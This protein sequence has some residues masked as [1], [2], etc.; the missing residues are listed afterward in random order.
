MIELSK[1]K[2]MKDIL[3]YAYN[4]IP[5]YKDVLKG[6]DMDNDV[7]KV[8]E[9]IPIQ[10]KMKMRDNE[11]YINQRMKCMDIELV[12]KITGG[13]TGEPWNIT[14]TFLES[15]R[16][17]NMLW[18]S[19]IQFGIKPNDHFYQFGGYGEIDGVFT[20]KQVIET[21]RFTE[22][23]MFHLNDRVLD[24]YIDIIKGGKGNWF[25]ANPSALYILAHRMRDRKIRGLG[26][27]KYV[28][29]TGERVYE[30]Q[31]ALI[32]EVFD[33][34][35]S[36]MYGS[37]E[38]TCISHRC[39][40]GKHHILPKVFVDVIDDDGKSIVSQEGK[41]GE[42]VV[43]SF[44]DKYMPFIKYRTG[45]YGIIDTTDDCPCGC[46]GVYFKKL[47]G[48][49]AAYVTVGNIKVHLEITYYLMEKFN[50]I[51]GEGI[52]QFQVIFRKPN[53]FHFKFVLDS[54]NYQK[55][56]KDFYVQELKA[57]VEQASVEIEFV[58]YI[59]RV[60]R[61]LNPYIIEE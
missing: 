52:R 9:A 2:C 46:R 11:K 47:E 4:E 49:K 22:F 58:K 25:F 28:E 1:K 54:A 43:T 19:R 33:C 50:R 61:K 45:D 60:K 59:E 8:Y 16:Y 37:R 7:D 5:Y 35:V 41:L 13:T 57:V 48:R 39:K 40:Y 32:A 29:L 34:P 3:K 17:F 55:T 31:E 26:N 10:C 36:I 23:S 42:I 12:T 20:T 51:Y 14:K 53:I 27:I 21:S 18:K 6:I 56:V 15:T 38:I 44:I 24:E 30:Y